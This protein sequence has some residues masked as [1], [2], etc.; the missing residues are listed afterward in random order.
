M[1]RV[2]L[3]L[4]AS[5]AA[6]GTL[7]LLEAR[8][9]AG[10]CGGGGDGG[11]G[12]SSDGG[13]SSSD[14][15]SGGGSDSY[16]AS[17]YTS[18]T[19][20]PTPA[21]VESSQVLGH[22]SC[23]GFGD[24]AMPR[25]LPHVTVEL[26]SSVRTFSMRGTRF[27]GYVDHGAEGGYTYV[28]T[29]GEMSGQAEAV[30]GDIR[31]LFGRRVYGGMEA[32]IG[33][34][35]GDP[36]TRWSEMPGASATSTVSMSLL[37]GGVVG[38]RTRLG[39]GAVPVTLAAE[40]FGGVHSLHMSV[41]SQYGDCIT[42]TTASDARLLVEPRARVEAWLSPWVSVGAFAGA[43]VLRDNAAAMGVYLGVHSRAFNGVR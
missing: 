27:D 38:A 4:L 26:G 37:G 2:E 25:W 36:Q 6:V 20:E 15:D 1:R 31:F 17:A 39:G 22:R 41:D 28:V 34:V 42:T 3:A 40:V 9:H 14:G 18:G 30:G 33:A 11:G 8:G 21:C 23:S 5:L 32:S 10:S 19:S 12:G 29:G 7:L 16:D 35:G 43:D 24:W 13:S